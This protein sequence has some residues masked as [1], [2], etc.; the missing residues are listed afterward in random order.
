MLVMNCG[1]GGGGGKPNACG[2]G[3]GSGPPYDEGI[4]MVPDRGDGPKAMDG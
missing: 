2:G 1:G 4:N 3:G